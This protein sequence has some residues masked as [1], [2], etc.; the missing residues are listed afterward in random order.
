[1]VTHDKLDEKQVYLIPELCRMT[2]LD[3]KSKND[4]P[5]MEKIAKYTRL[6]PNERLKHIHSLVKK[7]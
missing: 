5:L 7:L 2:G 4:V 6:D 1:L 3:K